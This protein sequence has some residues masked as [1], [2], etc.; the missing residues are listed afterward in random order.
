MGRRE[1][2]NMT[3]PTYGSATADNGIGPQPTNTIV[4]S[5]TPRV[6]YFNLETA[7]NCYPGRL[8]KKDTH[9]NDVEVCGA[10]GIA[11]GVLGYEQASKKYQPATRATIYSA[12]D[13]VPVLSGPGVIVMLYL[14]DDAATIVDGDPLVAAA[15]GKVTKGTAAAVPSGST[16]V[17]S[18][19]A[20]PTIAG[21][22][23]TE[24]LPVAKAREDVTVTDAGGWIMAE[25]L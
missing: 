1:P 4:V 20:Q 23:P 15:D 16:A 11:K 2:T 25:L 13:Q 19:S 9:S 3:A 24:G 14:S 6:R 21:N 17:T 22:I 8:V 7:T 12:S 5:G 18:T 10:A